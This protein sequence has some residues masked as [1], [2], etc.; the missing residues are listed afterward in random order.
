MN[1][2]ERNIE[3]KVI[4]LLKRQ[5]SVLIL[6]PRQTGKTTL[7]NRFKG[8]IFITFIKPE[9][10]Q[11]YEKSPGLLRGEVEALHSRLKRKPVVLLDEVQK[12]P[13]IMD[14]LQELIDR[15]MAVFI[16][17]GSSARKLRRGSSMNLLPGRVVSLR[18]DALN[19]AE[20]PDCELSELLLY[21]SLPGVVKVP[22]DKDREID[23]GSYAVTYLEE[24]IRAEA[25][26]RNLGSFARFLELAASESGMII[27][28][29][30]LSQEIGVA[31]TTIASY[32]DILDD[33]LIIERIEP[34]TESKTRKKL[35][36]SNKYVFF[37]LGVMRICANEPPI[38]HRSLKG[39]LFKQFIGLELI[40]S[41][42]ISDKSLKIKFWRDPCG[43]E[44]DWVIDKQGEYIPIEVKWT[45]TPNERDIKCLQ[46]FLEEYKN[47]QN[48]YLVC[49]TPR[50]VKLDKKIMAIPWE[51]IAELFDF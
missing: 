3:K 38:L 21:G 25:I 41:S 1:Y 7:L 40:R 35:T 50:E 27:N 33:C 10:R 4:G 31:H 34:I 47:S 36:R 23:L 16:I 44:V 14:I 18:L 43:P 48:G 5:K 37:D 42:H 39:F 11:R 46:K 12:V 22:D 45:D 13:E 17:T 26:V 20:M 28:F 9:E 30:K 8:D 2:I 51:N 15:D 19:I 24:E 32:F 49:R 29:R 6:G